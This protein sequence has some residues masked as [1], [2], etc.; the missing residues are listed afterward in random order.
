MNEKK[1]IPYWAVREGRS[2]GMFLNE[3]DC[4]K[5][6]QNYPGAEYFGFDNIDDAKSYLNGTPLEEI[7]KAITNRGSLIS[8]DVLV[9]SRNDEEVEA[10][11]RLAS[12][13]SLENLN[14]SSDKLNPLALKARGLDA[15]NFDVKIKFLCLSG[16]EVQNPFSSPE[17]EIAI[18]VRFSE[19]QEEGVYT[20]SGYYY[21]SKPINFLNTEN[22][23]NPTREADWVVDST[24]PRV[25]AEADFQIDLAKS[26][27]NRSNDSLD[28]V[29]MF[30]PTSIFIE[31]GT[32]KYERR[33]QD[34]VFTPLAK[35][36]IFI[37]GEEKAVGIML[38]LSMKPIEGAED[39]VITEKMKDEHLQLMMNTKGNQKKSFFARKKKPITM[40]LEDAKKLSLS[41]GSVLRVKVESVATN[42]VGRISSR[43]LD[44]E[45][46][47]DDEKS[48]FEVVEETVQ[49]KMDIA[50]RKKTRTEM[51]MVSK[52]GKEKKR[53]E[54]QLRKNKEILVLKK[55]EKSG[56]GALI[57][58]FREGCMLI[59]NDIGI[60]T[61]DIDKEIYDEYSAKKDVKEM[62]NMMDNFV[63]RNVAACGANCEELKGTLSSESLDYDSGL[64]DA[65]IGD[66]KIKASE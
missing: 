7:Q 52:R 65:T 66:F 22:A 35:S 55:E 18:G 42:T 25:A 39:V 46:V 34:D 64:E 30:I 40:N 33:I 59:A 1:E 43:T 41:R 62:R 9:Y 61:A 63:E 54:K 5:S 26:N 10:M 45:E 14:K 38:D 2:K 50:L 32:I 49:A 27:V 31:I 60:V 28:S 56:F 20:K 29:N 11:P 19:A 57:E 58:N 12:H 17:Q 15:V 3:E 44:V 13:T 36:T 48:Q 16:I 53:K 51:K 21:G 23:S 47:S 24:D 37:T 4:I 6:V 8:T